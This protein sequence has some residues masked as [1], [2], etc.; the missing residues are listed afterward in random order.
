LTATTDAA[1]DLPISTLIN[2]LHSQF[3]DLEDGALATYIPP[4]AT[5][6]PSWFGVSLATTDGHLY[7][8]G[9]TR[10]LF[11]IQSISK[12]FVYGMAL[13]DRGEQEVLRFVGVEPTGDPFNSITVEEETR[14]PYN[15]M[16][17]AGAIVTTSLVAG[18]NHDEQWARIIA[19]LSSFAGRRLDVDKAIF[20]AERETG[21]RNRAITYFMRALGMGPGN[22]DFALDLYFRQCSILVDSRDLAIMAA[23]LANHGV[24]P[25]TGERALG[26]RE[27][28]RVLSVMMTCGMYD[29]AG[30]WAF[31]VGIPAKSGVAGGILAVVPGQLGI[32]V[33]SPPLDRRGNSVRG[34]AICEQLSR[35]LDLHLYRTHLS[36]NS[37]VRRHYTATTVRSTRYRSAAAAE[38]IRDHGDCIAVFELQGDLYF[39]TTEMLTR[40]VAS[41]LHALKFIVFDTNR[42]GQIEAGAKRLLA[43]FTE[44]ART[45]GVESVV[46]GLPRSDRDDGSEADLLEALPNFPDVDRALEWCED[47]LL[48]MLSVPGASTTRDLA[49]QELLTG[50]DENMLAL[51]AERTQVRTFSAGEAVVNEGDP[52]RELFFVISGQVSVHLGLP[53]LTRRLACFGPGAA[54]GE[55]A[56]LDDGT[57][58]TTVL[59]DEPTTCGVLSRDSL[60]EISRHYPEVISALYRQ[61]ALNLSARLR[62]SNEMVRSLQ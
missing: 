57:R 39:A 29:F 18:D 24:N 8:S 21:D 59:A 6:D 34:V 11:T 31:R 53:G 50:F 19:G 37:V 10:R 16:V 55:M 60:E 30:E 43:E 48:E 26:E 17:N 12:A 49:D 45:H 1:R 15:P 25:V 3:Q 4:L 42:L 51:I 58:S 23:T 47:R 32:G 22:V 27:T 41:D 54:F 46:A 38:A 44:M 35:E 13:Q 20:D 40:A 5:A 33:F 2:G 62:D 52:A 61:I 7:E 14:R 56:L 9:E 36:P 28:V